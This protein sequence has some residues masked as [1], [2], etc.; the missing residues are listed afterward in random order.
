MV[1][2]HLCVL[3]GQEK[4]TALPNVYS[5]EFLNHNKLADNLLNTS[6]VS[7]FIATTILN[8]ITGHNSTPTESLF[9]SQNAQSILL[10]FNA[11]VIFLASF[12]LYLFFTK[13]NFLPLT[14]V[15]IMVFYFAL[16]LSDLLGFE[17]H[18]SLS[19][20]SGVITFF[21]VSILSSKVTNIGTTIRNCVYFYLLLNL[22]SVILIPGFAVQYNYDG[23]LSFRMH[24]IANQANS[25]APY[26]LVLLYVT[27]INPFGTKTINYLGYFMAFAILIA[28][29]SKTT[30]ILVGLFLAFHFFDLI[31]NVRK[32]Y[33]V[34]IYLFLIPLAG[35]L[36]AI[37]VDS[38]IFTV[39]SS[40]DSISS[41]SGRDIVWTAT[42]DA[43][44]LN[45]IFGYGYSSLWNDRMA[46]DFA[47]LYN[48]MPR[49]S[50]SLFFQVLGE[51]GI[52]GI[53]GLAVF[54]FYFIGA[55]I[56][57]AKKLYTTLGFFLVLVLFRGISEVTIGNGVFT[58]NSVIQIIIITLCTQSI[59]RGKND[60]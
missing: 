54:T 44:R 56:S 52:V 58:D 38:N 2:C 40:D 17:K 12:S 15:P 9:N 48:W 57:N 13:K 21:T 60:R 34:G 24:G 28:T 32:E 55:I 36:I 18:I 22:A 42:L 50:H 46:G 29:Q 10:Y 26:C 19:L 30:W 27:I 16:T 43:W 11:M 51:A 59:V 37:I 8:L 20:I 49:Y 4:M 7:I 25:L 45:P 3:D 41:F 14:S 47:S 23:F 6:F 31:K 53:I 1:N 39:I 5:G 33:K 35:V